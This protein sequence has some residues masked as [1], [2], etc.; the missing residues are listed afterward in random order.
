MPRERDVVFAL[1]QLERR[2]AAIEAHL[3]LSPPEPP[4][5]ASP[6]VVELIATGRTIEA[7]KQLREETG[8]ALG[9]A[10]D[11]VERIREGRGGIPGG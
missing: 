10:K 6:A 8:M 2:I 9:E 11:A 4:R 3:G 1:G 7:I 5:E